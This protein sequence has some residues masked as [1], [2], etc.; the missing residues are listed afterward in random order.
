M[1]EF[2]EHWG[3]YQFVFLLYRNYVERRESK[4]KNRA[5]YTYDLNMDKERGKLTLVR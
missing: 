5:L 2:L 3:E 4:G 1:R